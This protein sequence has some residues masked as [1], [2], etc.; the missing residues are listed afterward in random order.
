MPFQ[1]LPP[2]SRTFGPIR[3]LSRISQSGRTLRRTSAAGRNV[4]WLLDQ[5][6]HR[7]ATKKNDTRVLPGLDSTL[8][9]CSYWGPEECFSGQWC[10]LSASMWLSLP[11]LQEETFLLFVSLIYIERQALGTFIIEGMWELT[12][13]RAPGGATGK[14]QAAL[15]E[16]H[17]EGVV[18]VTYVLTCTFTDSEY[19][20]NIR[21]RRLSFR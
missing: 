17:L 1:A 20:L 11:T 4:P 9:K 7:V 3:T 8:G 12:W 16:W 6:V 18:R 19:I 14:S 21:M 2:Q 13:V 5:L 10:Y 15:G